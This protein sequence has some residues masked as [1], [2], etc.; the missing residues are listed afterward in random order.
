MFLSDVIETITF[1]LYLQF[2]IYSTIF[3][4]SRLIIAVV[5][6]KGRSK[7]T[8]HDI[9]KMLVNVVFGKGLPWQYML[10]YFE[11]QTTSLF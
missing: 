11:N 2:N 4:Q 3:K 9:S 10:R 6:V 1:A 8:C 7:N 5:L